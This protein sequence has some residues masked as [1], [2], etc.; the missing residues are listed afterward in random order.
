VTEGWRKLN[1]DIHDMNSLPNMIRVTKSSRMTWAVY[2]AHMGGGGG[3]RNTFGI[4]V[5]KREG[6]KPLSESRLR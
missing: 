5:G 1:N 4:L 2:L 3:G 6:K